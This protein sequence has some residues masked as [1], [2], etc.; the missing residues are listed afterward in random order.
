MKLFVD[1]RVL[2]CIRLWRGVGPDVPVP[3]LPG[4][5][6]LRERGRESGMHRQVKSYRKKTCDMRIRGFVQKFRV[7][8]FD[9]AEL[10][11]ALLTGRQTR[12]K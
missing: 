8:D 1:R 4:H 7:K 6:G 12:K 9:I 2:F 11:L 3:G 5:Q 10:G